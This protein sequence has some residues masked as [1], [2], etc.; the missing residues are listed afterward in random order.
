MKKGENHEKTLRNLWGE[1][2]TS[3]H[4]LYPTKD[5]HKVAYSQFR[6]TFHLTISHYP[7]EWIWAWVKSNRLGNR[8]SRSLQELKD[9]L[10][11]AW[12][13]VRRLDMQVFMTSGT[14]SDK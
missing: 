11:L 13:Q 3:T 14:W 7:I 12:Q 1:P 10:R 9:R 5:F 2:L 4:I 8:L 6:M